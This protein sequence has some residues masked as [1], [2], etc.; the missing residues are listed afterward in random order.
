LTLLLVGLLA[1]GVAAWVLVGV[2]FALLHL[3]ELLAVAGVA[4]WAG[5]RLGNY[6]GRHQR[7]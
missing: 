7:P 5:Y 3:I 2:A 6:R 1:I 4:G